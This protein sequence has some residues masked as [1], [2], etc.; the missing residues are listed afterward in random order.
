MSARRVDNDAITVIA[1]DKDKNSQHALKWAVENILVDS[2]DCV[3]LHV[4]PKG[5]IS[6][7]YL[8]SSKEH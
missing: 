1:I 5:I 3:L 8:S 7:L 4:E 2:P 6:N